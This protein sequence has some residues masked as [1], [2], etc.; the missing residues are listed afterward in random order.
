M[1][2]QDPDDGAGSAVHVE[3]QLVET[4]RR[5]EPLSRS[6]AKQRRAGVAEAGAHALAGAPAEGLS[7]RTE[8]RHAPARGDGDGAGLRPGLLLA[9][10]PTTALDVT[11]QATGAATIPRPAAAA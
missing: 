9:D 5:H 4:I 11:V 8:R 2:F 3:Q 6:A 10:E 7:V 1:M